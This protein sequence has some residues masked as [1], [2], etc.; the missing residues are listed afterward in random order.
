MKV[1]IQAFIFSFL[2]STLFSAFAQEK[3][4]A[5]GY[6]EKGKAS[7]YG[8]KLHGKL[9]ANGEKY[10]MF[11]KTA[12]HPSI[13]FNSIIKVT[14]LNSPDKW[15]TL[16]INDRGP[17]TKSRI[18]D[19]SKRAALK[20][21]MEKTG[22]LEVELEILKVGDNQRVV[23][24]ED[25]TKK[26]VNTKLVA[27]AE[28]DVKGN[29]KKTLKEKKNDKKGTEKT[30]AKKTKQKSVKPTKAVVQSNLPL[31]QR[32]KNTG[33]YNVWGTPVKPKGYGLQIAA[34]SDINQAIKVANE[35]ESLGLKGLYIQSG[36]T[37]EE[38]SYRLL[39]GAWQDVDEAQDKI[40]IAK[41]KGF[42]TAFVKSHF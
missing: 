21:N 42:P 31:N 19:I 29:E 30:L 8:E 6:K 33:T 18:L 27:S 10:D 11:S 26:D 34:Y 7:Y 40:I 9:T 38:V 14:N 36:W 2:C 1:I 28:K 3:K 32:F 22:V 15:V 4:Y 13:P 12:A 16:R 37:N 35:A 24:S 23:Y 5:I 41:K 39:Y 20:L 17:F 25:S